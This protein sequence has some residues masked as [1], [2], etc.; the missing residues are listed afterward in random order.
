MSTTV[1]I[2][3]SWQVGHCP[4]YDISKPRIRLS[5]GDHAMRW[6][7]HD[8]STFQQTATTLSVPAGWSDIILSGLHITNPFV[9]ALES[10]H[11]EC[12]VHTLYLD[13]PDEITGGD[14]AAIV[15]FAPAAR[16][17]RRLLT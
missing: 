12:S 10:M 3:V 8:P 6:F 5:E 4:P 11:N 13:R 2:D 15:A 7:I 14:V 16:P 17:T 1:E 9:E